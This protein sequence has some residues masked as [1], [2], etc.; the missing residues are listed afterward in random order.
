MWVCLQN[1]HLSQSWMPS[2][3]R[4]VDNIDPEKVFI[5]FVFYTIVYSHKVEYVKFPIQKAI[6]QTIEQTLEFIQKLI[7]FFF[8]FQKFMKFYIHYFCIFRI[9]KGHNVLKYSKILTNFIICSKNLNFITNHFN[10]RYLKL[11]Y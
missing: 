7:S 1:C 4:I 5:V 10:T 3:D 11:S 2:L 9:S 8:I 6:L